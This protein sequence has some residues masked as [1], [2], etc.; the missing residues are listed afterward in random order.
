[1]WCAP[2]GASAANRKASKSPDL[3]NGSMSSRKLK[4]RQ[5]KIKRLSI[6]ATAVGAVLAYALIT[7]AIVDVFLDRPA[8]AETAQ[9]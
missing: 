4:K 8:A 9:Q 2:P 6:M 3:E 1:L 7:Y 5:A